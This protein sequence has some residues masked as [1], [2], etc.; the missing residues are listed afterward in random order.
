MKGGTWVSTLGQAGGEGL[1]H[2]MGVRSQGWAPGAGQVTA[3]P[4]RQLLLC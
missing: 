2:P 4:A 1:L 3:H